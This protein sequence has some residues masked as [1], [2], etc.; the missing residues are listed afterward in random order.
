MTIAVLEMLFMGFIIIALSFIAIHIII[1]LSLIAI[2]LEN[3]KLAL[4]KAIT[5]I[6][7]KR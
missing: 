5:K 4:D 6:E 7:G 2:Q 3:I 1:A